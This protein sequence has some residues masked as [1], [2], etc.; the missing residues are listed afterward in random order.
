MIRPNSDRRVLGTTYPADT[1][2]PGSK[3]L[4][5]RGTSVRELVA[6]VLARAGLLVLRAGP[7]D[8]VAVIG[9]DQL[10][11]QWRWGIARAVRAQTGGTAVFLPSNCRVHI[12][13]RAVFRE[14]RGT[15]TAG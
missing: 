4:L 5:G 11:P 7:Q 3:L 8:A 14:D 15:E 9:G 10:T 13:K 6:S 1:A 2:P 12:E